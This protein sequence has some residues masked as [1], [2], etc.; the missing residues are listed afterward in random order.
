MNPGQDKCPE[1][2]GQQNEPGH[3]KPGRLAEKQEVYQQ[4]ENEIQVEEDKPGGI[5][6]RDF[7]NC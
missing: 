3:L 4:P 6:D 2:A 5:H 1:D 7:L